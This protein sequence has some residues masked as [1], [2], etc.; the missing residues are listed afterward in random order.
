MG[1]SGFIAI[2]AITV[3]CYLIAEICKVTKL[4]NK[5]LPVIC[6]ACGGLIGL[7]AMRFMADFPSGDYITSLAVGIASG[8]A[9]TGVN[10]IAK[11]FSSNG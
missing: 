2:P 1:T 8:L 5:W 3:I 9:A 6:G 11:Q 4:D 7:I 10:Q